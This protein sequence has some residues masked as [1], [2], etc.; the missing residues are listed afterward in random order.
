MLNISPFFGQ[1]M[2]IFAKISMSRSV[3]VA[4]PLIRAHGAVLAIAVGYIFGRYSAFLAVFA[5]F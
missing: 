2:L 3:V 1:F 5:H 4:V